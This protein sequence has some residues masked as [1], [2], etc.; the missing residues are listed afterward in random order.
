M[1]KTVELVDMSRAARV[2]TRNPF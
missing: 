2:P 1:V